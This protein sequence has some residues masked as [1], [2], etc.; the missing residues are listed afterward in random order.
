MR[1]SMHKKIV[2]KTI[3]F[4][5][6]IEKSTAKNEIQDYINNNPG[7]LT[8]DVIE[9]LRI[10]PPL[11]VEIIQELKNEGLIVSQPLE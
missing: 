3:T 2:V 6:N 8:S 5:Y 9:K 7:A 10:E 4:R 1:S 11:A